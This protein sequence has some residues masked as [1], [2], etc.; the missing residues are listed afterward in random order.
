LLSAGCEHVNARDWAFAPRGECHLRNGED[1]RLWVDRAD[2]RLL[3][4]D[5]LV[6]QWAGRHGMFHHPAVTLADRVVTI[7][8]ANRTVVYRLVEHV[9]EW[10]AWIAEWPD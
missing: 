6:E 9:P 4:S 3:I 5:G 1:G 10:R 7:R 2:P 8:A